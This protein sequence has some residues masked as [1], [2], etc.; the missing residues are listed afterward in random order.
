MTM[1]P[2]NETYESSS[3]KDADLVKLVE[4]SKSIFQSFRKGKL[5]TEEE[6]KYFT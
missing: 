6:L 4:K 2:M 5:T 1:R 3:F